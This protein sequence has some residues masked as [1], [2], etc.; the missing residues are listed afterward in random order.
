MV[1]R[2]ALLVPSR[3]RP[4]N[5]K[6]L[7]NDLVQTESFVDLFVGVD[8]DE[9]ALY[10]PNYSPDEGWLTETPDT[11]VFVTYRVAP[12]LRLAGTLNFLASRYVNRYDIIGFMGDDHAPRGDWS[13]RID[14]ELEAMGVGMVYGDDGHQG[15]NIPT[16]IFM[17]SNIVQVL[18]WMVPPGMQH[19]YLDNIW[20]DLGEGAGCL[21]YLPDVKIEHLHPHAGKAEWDERYEEVN[22]QEQYSVD[23]ARYN[24]WKQNEMASD[25]AKI[26]A[27]M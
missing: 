2:K 11:G 4:Q 9:T 21:K 22:S 6:R 26:K 8:D 1:M 20:K 7:I 12:R 5:I 15:A 16:A 10:C 14:Q 25:I 19:M 23:L 24:E 27:I 13:Y 3:G 17:T 18:G